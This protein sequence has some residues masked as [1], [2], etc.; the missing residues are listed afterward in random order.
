MPQPGSRHYLAFLI[1]VVVGC[2]APTPESAPPSAP[3]AAI[4]VQF[5]PARVGSISGRV[6]WDGPIPTFPPVIAPL[7]LPTGVEQRPYP[8]PNAPG[9]DPA[10]RAVRGAVVYLDGVAPAHS[11]PWHHAPLRVAIRE[12]RLAIIQG[13]AE[14]NVGF[15]HAGDDMEMVSQDAAVHVLS[16]RGAAFF[17]LAFPDPDRPL[18]RTLDQVGLVDLSSGA[19][20]YWHRTFLFVVDHPY[21]ALTAADGTFALEQVPPGQYVLK[22]WLPNGTVARTERDPNTGLILRYI[23][24][25]ALEWA[26]PV[27]VEAGGRVTAAPHLANRVGR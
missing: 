14:S 11:K 20:R 21:Y 10:T 27:R 1:M 26:A 19:G 3:P 23:H 2:D 17:A 24:A 25:A 8:H 22:C 16:A 9:I 6:N 5:D 15:V 18:R 4:G 12:D 13:S 7:F